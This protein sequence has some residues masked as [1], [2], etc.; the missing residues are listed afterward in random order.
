MY[1]VLFAVYLGDGDTQERK[2]NRSPVEGRK[3]ESMPPPPQIF[4]FLL[5]RIDYGAPFFVDRGRE[6]ISRETPTSVFE[7][8]KEEG[9]G[10][11]RDRASLPSSSFSIRRSL[12]SAVEKRCQEIYMGEKGGFMINAF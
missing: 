11:K 10:R 8:G 3:E 6:D 9:G 7:R 12:Q 5:R 1:T 2:K 4:F